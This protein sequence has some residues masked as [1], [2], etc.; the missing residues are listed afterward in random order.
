MLA[1]LLEAATKTLSAAAHRRRERAVSA[2]VRRGERALAAGFKAQGTAFLRKLATQRASFPT[3]EALREGANDV[4]DW[5]PLFTAAELATLS[6]LEKPLSAIVRAALAAGIRV[7]VADLKTA[8][9]FNLKHPAAVAY[10][11]EHGAAL[12][13]AINEHTRSRIRSIM[14]QA[15]DEGWSYDRTA[16][17]LQDLYQGFSVGK[18]QLHIDSR[19]HLIAV[20]EAKDAYEHGNALV[21]HELAAAG[22]DMQKF[23][24]TVGDERVS[25]ECHANEVAGWIPF[26]VLYPSGKDRPLQHVGCRCTQLLRHAPDPK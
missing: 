11:Q 21:G 12:V 26:A 20:Q 24:L 6:V 8:I 7:S 13:T 19:A 3:T 25:A 17:Q 22:L 23:W 5:E 10:V 14:T 16:K 15:V 1:R 2:T 9:A 18:P 4:L